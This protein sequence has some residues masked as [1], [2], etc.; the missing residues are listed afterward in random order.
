MSSRAS[1]CSS[2]GRT[3]ADAR[4]PRLSY[5]GW[6]SRVESGDA[7]RPPAGCCSLLL[8]VVPH[9][10]DPNAPEPMQ[11]YRYAAEVDELVIPVFVFIG[12]WKQ[13]QRRR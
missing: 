6:L 2:H 11:V 8:L 4:L 12:D 10:Q 5:Q 3:R 7:P 9:L 13:Y 1:T